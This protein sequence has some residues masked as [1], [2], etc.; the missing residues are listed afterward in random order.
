M[1]SIVKSIPPEPQGA[2]PELEVPEQPEPPRRRGLAGV[3]QII[4]VIVAVGLAVA[5]SRDD[6]TV[7]VAP[8]SAYTPSAQSEPAVPLARVMLPERRQTQISLEAT[9]T[10]EVRNTVSLSPQIGGQVISVSDSLRVGG[11]FEA[12]EVLFTIDPRDYELALAQAEASLAGAEARLKLRQAESAAA[13]ENYA[14]LHGDDPVPDLVAKVPQIE[15]STA[16]VASAAARVARAELDLS[17][18]QFSLPFSG[19][20]AASSIAPGQLL[21]TGQDYGEVFADDAIEVSVPVD[22]DDLAAIDPVIG[23]FAEVRSGGQTFSAIVERRSAVLDERTRFARLYLSLAETADLPPGTFVDVALKGAELA[24]TFVIPEAAQ[25][26]QGNLWVVSNGAL[27]EVEP[28]VLGRLRD[29]LVVAPFDYGEGVVLGSIPGAD[30]G[31]RVI[32]ERGGTT[33]IPGG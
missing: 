18:T 13:R 32:T 27:V 4:A 28:T 23:R 24:E 22:D 31:S 16:D 3:L 19:H 6:S 5:Y 20:I 10:I 17:R 7:T 15:Q 30:V 21:T 29:G 8:P 9:G 25:R 14:L 26:P 2:S 11:S 1:S 12:G 33:S